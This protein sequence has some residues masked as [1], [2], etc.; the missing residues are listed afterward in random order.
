M[1][2]CTTCDGDGW[3]AYHIG[4]GTDTRRETCTDCDGTGQSD[5]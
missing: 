2:K 5:D 3:I 1:A 4:G